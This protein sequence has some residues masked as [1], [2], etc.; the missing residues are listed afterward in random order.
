M[1]ISDF[2]FR[3]STRRSRNDGLCRVRTFVCGD[4]S[5][6]AL[7]TDVGSLGTGHSVTNTIEDIREGL[8]RQGLVPESAKL[9]E[10]YESV[11][12][13][14]TFD[15]LSFDHDQNPRWNKITLGL[16]LA[17]AKASNQPHVGFLDCMA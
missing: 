7:I 12:G 5:V 2:I 1:K 10:H 16:T 8:V 11:S 13:T 3:F 17:R 14:A 15:V 4:S 9:I 6:T